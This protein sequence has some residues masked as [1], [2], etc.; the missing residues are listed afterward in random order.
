MAFAYILRTTTKS[1]GDPVRHLFRF[2]FVT[3]VL[4]LTSS[5]CGVQVESKIGTGTNA[6]EV[7]ECDNGT[8]LVLPKE[9]VNLR[10]RPIIDSPSLGVL[11][12]GTA[13]T[14]QAI[15]SVERDWWLWWPVVVSSSGDAS[16]SIQGWIAEK[17]V[18]GASYVIGSWNS[19]EF[20]VSAEQANVRVWPGT[21][22]EIIAQVNAG[23]RLQLDYSPLWVLQ[24][25]HVWR[26]VASNDDAGWILQDSGD[27]D[28]EQN[29]LGCSLLSD[30][31]SDAS[32]APDAATDAGVAT[33]AS[34]APL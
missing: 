32:I 26:Y 19:S 7:D 9:G 3:S 21:D 4:I 1:M 12:Q 13:V 33:D 25:G 31:L 30:T 18:E 8:M 29:N 24:H 2:Y 23:D 10:Q 34:A 6:Q 14:V 22:Q 17:T 28:P 27:L 5:A 16:T 11:E 15:D 20:L